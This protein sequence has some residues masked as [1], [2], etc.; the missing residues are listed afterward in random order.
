MRGRRATRL[1]KLKLAQRVQPGL[2]VQLVLMVLGARGGYK[3]FEGRR[4]PRVTL[5]SP[6]L[7]LHEKAMGSIASDRTINRG[8]DIKSVQMPDEEGSNPCHLIDLTGIY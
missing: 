2:P 8:H 5:V 1:P 4:E 7:G 6:G 3:A